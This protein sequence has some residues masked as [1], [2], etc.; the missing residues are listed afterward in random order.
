MLQASMENRSKDPLMRRRDVVPADITAGP[1]AE[2][3]PRKEKKR[4]KN[5]KKEMLK[6]GTE[7]LVVVVVLE[8]VGVLLLA[9]T[10][11]VVVHVVA[12]PIP[13]AKEM[14]TKK[15]AKMKMPQLRAKGRKEVKVVAGEEVEEVVDRVAAAEVTLV[16]SIVEE[17]AV[18]Q[19]AVVKHLIA[20]VNKN[21]LQ[22]NAELKAYKR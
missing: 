18:A 5:E 1:A 15:R 3:T 19:V 9:I 17:H 21:P 14:V 6:E 7:V 20:V 22:A 2:A 13:K 8:V 16:D 12:V 11:V 4:A 10:V